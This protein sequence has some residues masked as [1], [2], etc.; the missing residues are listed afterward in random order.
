MTTLL[1][2]LLLFGAGCFLAYLKEIDRLERD[3]K[4]TRSGRKFLVVTFGALGLSFLFTLWSA[5]AG[6]ILLTLT[7]HLCAALAGICAG[8]WL[9]WLIFCKRNPDIFEE[10]K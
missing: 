8:Q 2:F 9:A 6:L 10:E 3:E 1:P 4:P 5:D 7:L